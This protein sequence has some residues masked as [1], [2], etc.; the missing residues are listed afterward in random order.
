[1][2]LLKVSKDKRA[3]KFIKKRMSQP[4]NKDGRNYVSFLFSPFPYEY[5]AFKLIIF[6]FFCCFGSYWCNMMEWRECSLGWV[7]EQEMDAKVLCQKGP[8]LRD[9]GLSCY[10]SVVCMSGAGKMKAAP[11]EIRCH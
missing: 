9:S 3:L 5:L 1:M 7:G 8:E 11:M 4:T 10:Y 6:N 2:E